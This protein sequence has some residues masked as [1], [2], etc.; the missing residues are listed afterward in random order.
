MPPKSV[1]RL[2]VADQAATLGRLNAMLADSFPHVAFGTIVHLHAIPGVLFEPADVLAPDVAAVKGNTVLFVDRKLGR[3]TDVAVAGDAIHI[4]HLDMGHMGKIDAL[5]LFGVNQP[6]R[7]LRPVDVGRLGSGIL[8][9]QFRGARIDGMQVNLS[10]RP[11]RRET[12]CAYWVPRNCTTE[13]CRSLS[14]ISRQ[15]TPARSITKTSPRPTPR[16]QGS[17]W[18]LLLIWILWSKFPRR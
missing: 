2:F 7:V 8:V 3:F 17:Y 16:K 5:G 14:R 15:S 6:G 12:I 1:N 10:T 13:C 9:D 18:T 4:A 11:F